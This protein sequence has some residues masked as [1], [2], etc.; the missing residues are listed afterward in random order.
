MWHFYIRKGKAYVPTVAQTDAGFFLDIEPVTV[1]PADDREAL[2]RAIVGVIS[3]GNPTVAAP[4]RGA[5]PTPVVLQVAGVKTWS[6]FEKSA[7]C[8]TVYRT[9][10][11][12]EIPAME[13]AADG[14]VENPQRARKLPLSSSHDDVARA[15]VEQVVA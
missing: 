1:L 13:R 6:T 10:S 9:E 12:C 2:V 3:A 11:R 7:R 5:Y 15:L 14:W 4:V 8:Y